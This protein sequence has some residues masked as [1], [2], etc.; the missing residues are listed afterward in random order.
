MG[1][2]MWVYKNTQDNKARFLLGESGSKRLICIGVNPST[3]KPKDLDRTLTNVKR[4]S[5]EKGYD[6]WLM[7]NLYP[8]RATYPDEL[9]EEMAKK[10]HEENLRWIE[11]ELS[12]GENEIWAA[13]GTLIKKR[14]YLLNCCVDIF[15]ITNNHKTKWYTIGKISKHGH[16]HHPLYLKKGLPLEQFDVRNYLKSQKL[17]TLTPL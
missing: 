1:S 13:W 16:P 3:A 15:N 6:S 8:Q 14:K 2:K 5:L 10:Y 4:V 11:T 17:R 7:I 12:S 9:H